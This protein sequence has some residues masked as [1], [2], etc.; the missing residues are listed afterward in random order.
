MRNS[1]EHN[2]ISDLTEKLENLR[3]R[4]TE[5]DRDIT[6]VQQQLSNLQKEN[7]IGHQH[8]GRR[9]RVLN[10]G[11]HQ[12]SEG[13]IV[14]FTKG[15]RPFVKIKEK[16]FSEIRRLPK[17]LRLLPIKNKE[18]HSFMI[19]WLILVT[20]RVQRKQITKRKQPKQMNN[21]ELI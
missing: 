11:K 9:C 13:R 3:I 19:S 16:G 18:E 1:I 20:T 6:L 8:I 2:T 4:Q 5:I 15:V 21:Q 14:G 7:N 17:N 12:P 10:S